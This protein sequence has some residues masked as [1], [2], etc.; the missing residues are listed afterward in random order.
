MVLLHKWDAGEQLRFIE[1]EGVTAFSG[2]PA[3][4]RQ[5]VDHPDASNFDLSSLRG[6]TAGAL[7]HHRS[8]SD[9]REH[10]WELRWCV[11]GY[12]FTETSTVVTMTSGDGYRHR[13]DS[14]GVAIPVDDLRV[15]DDTG[16]DV[17]TGAVGE[18]LVRGPNIV[19]GDKRRADA[20]AQSFDSAGWFRTGDIARI[21][22]DEFVYIVDRATDLIN[23]GGENLS[24]VEV[25]AILFEHRDVAD[26]AVIPVPHDVLG[27]EVGAVVQRRAGRW[28]TEAELRD[29]AGAPLA[30]FKVPVR[31]WMG[32]EPLQRSPQGKVL[33]QQLPPSC[34][35][36]VRR[37]FRF[38]PS[39]AGRISEP[40]DR[41]P[42]VDGQDGTRGEAAGVGCEV[43]RRADDLVG[44][45]PTL[46][47][48][49]SRP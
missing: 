25:E 17:A 10:R 24:S 36:D 35:T 22:V 37:A 9:E 5:L 27:E 2:V 32:D 18:S 16:D 39:P 19:R 31:F 34:S 28:V 29:H 42:S 14:V 4:V 3:M 23:R 38:P 44:L 48:E 46:E 49:V 47:R 6:V 13:P 21:N 26:V 7:Q 12:G 8:W 30:A 40:S 33:K 15:V 41:A 45:P 11:N 20:T 43:E 1:S